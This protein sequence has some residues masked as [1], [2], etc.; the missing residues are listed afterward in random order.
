MSWHA[1]QHC[2]K[3]H[4]SSHPEER[5]KEKRDTR[6]IF[7][8]S[9]C[10]QEGLAPLVWFFLFTFNVLSESQQRGHR[11]RSRCGYTIQWETP[12]CHWKCNLSVV[13]QAHLIYNSNKGPFTAC[14]EFSALE[15]S[16][17]LYWAMVQASLLRGP[18]AGKPCLQKAATALGINLSNLAEGRSRGG[19]Y[20]KAEQLLREVLEL[21]SVCLSPSMCR[22]LPKSARLC[23]V[24]GAPCSVKIAGWKLMQWWW[25][26]AKQQSEALQ[27]PCISDV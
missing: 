19:N 27:Q 2:S 17:H 20:I 22:C 5:N 10:Q 6:L 15:E 24:S 7:S 4:G 14:R 13:R 1:E 11:T 25:N 26:A 8:K 23:M 21:R 18:K 3:M 9:F 16:R 12:K